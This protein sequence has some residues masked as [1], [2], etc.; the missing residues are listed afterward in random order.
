MSTTYRLGSSPAIY[1]PGIFA[2]MQQ[3]YKSNPN[4]A[5]EVI[6]SGWAIPADVTERALKGDK[7]VIVE[8]D[9]DEELVTITAY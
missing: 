4:H 7:S 1:A 8:I 2:A 6:G 3:E 9:E 5:V